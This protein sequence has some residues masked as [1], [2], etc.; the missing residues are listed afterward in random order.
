MQVVERVGGGY[1]GFFHIIYLRERPARFSSCCGGRR[2]PPMRRQQPGGAGGCC[3]QAWGSGAGHDRSLCRIQRDEIYL[4][5]DSLVEASM[6]WGSG[7][8]AGASCAGYTDLMDSHDD[9][10]AY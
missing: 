2:P 10:F 4:M 3:R 1:R 7:H 6:V 5:T 9:V 8:G